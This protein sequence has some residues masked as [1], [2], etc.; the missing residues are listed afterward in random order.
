MTLILSKLPQ[1][2]FEQ[3]VLAGYAWT[4]DDEDLRKA[5]A[6][7]MHLSHATAKSKGW[8]TDPTTGEPKE[9]NFGEVLMLMVSELSEALEA[10]RKDLMDD[11]LPDRRGIE[12]EFG[13][14]SI[15]I[16]DTAAAIPEIA[17]CIAGQVLKWRRLN[18]LSRPE[19]FG[20][21]LL[22]ATGCLYRA[23]AADIRGNMEDAAEELALCL[24]KLLCLA[25]RLGLDLS[26]AIVAKNRYNQ[27]REDHS[28]E[29]RAAGGKKY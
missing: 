1:E 22:E 26:G 12:V 11:K 15:R 24:A 29:A 3:L 7:A 28:L 27:R 18:A 23:Y 2:H 5:V 6:A 14:C 17:C 20:E 13:D 10:D 9:R 19:N 8:Y 16:L 21:A 4:S 25:E